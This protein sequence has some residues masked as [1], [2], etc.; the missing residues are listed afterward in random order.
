VVV[1]GL[2]VFGVEIFQMHESCMPVPVADWVKVPLR[3]V[4]NTVCVVEEEK[5]SRNPPPQKNGGD[6]RPSLFPHP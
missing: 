1:G 5:D 2:S 3:T 4:D 6:R